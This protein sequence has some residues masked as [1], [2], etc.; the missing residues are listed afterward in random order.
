MRPRSTSIRRCYALAFVFDST[1][2]LINRL[3]TVYLTRLRSCGPELRV[4]DHIRLDCAGRW[5]KAF[6]SVNR[7]AGPEILGLTI[8]DSNCCRREIT[9]GPGRSLLHF[10][11]RMIRISEYPRL[12][13]SSANCT[14]VRTYCPFAFLSRTLTPP[15]VRRGGPAT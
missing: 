15:R 6:A 10:E 13:F 2:W 9:S 8:R 7:N 11:F 12:E 3:P 14:R 1:R 5:S 4:A